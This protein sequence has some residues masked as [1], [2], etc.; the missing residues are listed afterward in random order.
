MKCV[1]TSAYRSVYC[2]YVLG[3]PHGVVC[4][5]ER[6]RGQEVGG[7]SEGIRGGEGGARRGGTS[8][9]VRT[10][11]SLSFMLPSILFDSSSSYILLSTTLSIVQ[12]PLFLCRLRWTKGGRD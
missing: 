1:S 5:E 4:S 8:V 3:M 9:S 7:R 2:V 12:D 11:S 10:V 6:D